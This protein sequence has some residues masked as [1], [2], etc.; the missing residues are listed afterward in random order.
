MKVF[1]GGIAAAFLGII[2][3]FIWF[4][5]FLHLLAGA[6][7]LM[8][9]L[10]GAMAAYLGYDEVKDQ[11]PFGKKKEEEEA[12]PAAAS[13]DVSKY[14]EEAEKYKQ[15]VEKLKAELEKAKG[16]AAS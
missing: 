11:L 10:G 4:K 9:L 16:E 13:E 15:E 12:A 1:L 14:K 5:P 8:L 7:P 6:V 2:G 3:I